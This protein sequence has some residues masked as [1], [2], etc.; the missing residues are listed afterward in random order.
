MNAED[1]PR[2]FDVDELLAFHRAAME[3]T[4]W[5]PQPLRDGHTGSLEAGAAR[6]VWAGIY[7]DADFVRQCAVLAMGSAEAQA[8]LD[9]NKRTAIVIARAF[10]RVNGWVFMGDPR[11]WAMQLV[12]MSERLHE[13]RSNA[14]D[15]FEEWTRTHVR[16]PKE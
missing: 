4:G 10:L 2:Y 8:F 7:E 13:G 16:R 15:L 1:L 5:T 14:I 3:A 11:E 9:G 6:A 12:K